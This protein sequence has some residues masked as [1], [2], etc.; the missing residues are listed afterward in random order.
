[1][2]KKQMVTRDKVLSRVDKKVRRRLGMTYDAAAGRWR[3]YQGTAGRPS[4]APEAKPP[5]A[6]PPEA[7]PPEAAS[8]SRV[9]QTIPPAHYHEKLL[10]LYAG[11]VL[12]GIEEV[13]RHRIVLDMQAEVVNDDVGRTRKICAL[14]LPNAAMAPVL[15]FL[16]Q[17][18]VFQIFRQSKL[19]LA[20]AVENLNDHAGYFAAAYRKAVAELGSPAVQVILSTV[21]H[22]YL[23]GPEKFVPTW[24]VFLELAKREGVEITFPH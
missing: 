24:R 21:H 6:K 8:S 15:G 23:A 17:D 1:M 3:P 9:V 5:E 4:P 2:A 20:E 22:S 7:K 18:R 13:N 19:N 16:R 11:S 10:R 12:D 14:G